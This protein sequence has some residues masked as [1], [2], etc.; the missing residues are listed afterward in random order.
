MQITLSDK[1]LISRILK[2]LQLKKKKF[3]E[4]RTCIGISTK[5]IYKCF[6]INRYSYCKYF[7]YN[8]DIFFSLAYCN[9]EYDTYKIQNMCQLPLLSVT[10]P[11]N[12]RLLN[13][14]GVKL[15]MN[16]TM[17]GSAPLTPVLFKGQLYFMIPL[18]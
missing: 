10:L 2:E 4:Q 13:S 15:Y 3:N 9:T 18:I 5:P 6:S 8:F 1:G 11:V 14:G 16:L 7:P 17:Q 12:S